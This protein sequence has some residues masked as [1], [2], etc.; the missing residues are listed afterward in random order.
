MQRLP[1]CLLQPL[2]ASDE[3]AL[4]PAASGIQWT[5]SW[6]LLPALCGNGGG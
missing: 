2:A 1:Q 4:N 3:R 6:L 5:R